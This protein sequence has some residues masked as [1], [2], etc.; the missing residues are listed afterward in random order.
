MNEDK[1]KSVG[2]YSYS[3]GGEAR[4]SETPGSLCEGSMAG[5]LGTGESKWPTL[6]FWSAAND[7]L[8]ADMA[9]KNRV[10][11][12]KATGIGRSISWR[13]EKGFVLKWK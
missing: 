6:S 4:Q 10:Q 2:L 3:D 5:V 11:D 12:A 1:K 8:V 9:S 7:S 13:K